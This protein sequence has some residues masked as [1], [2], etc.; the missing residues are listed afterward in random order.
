[1]AV[2]KFA[3]P[4]SNLGALQGGKIKWAGP[5]SYTQVTPGS[6]PTGGDQLPASD[7]GMGFVSQIIGGITDDCSFRVEGVLLAG[8]TKVLLRWT[9]L[10]T[11][12]LGGQSQTAGAEAAA[13]SDLH[14]FTINL[15]AISHS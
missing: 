12:T 1:M 2:S 8:G 13:S 9:S 5:T 14:T 11:A 15:F 7:F 10:R 4:A 6:P 3:W